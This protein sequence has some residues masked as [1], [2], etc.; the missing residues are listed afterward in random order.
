MPRE[1]AFTK[2]RRL[3]AAA[4]VTV[5]RADS[6]GV[7]AFCKGD[8]GTRL[9]T[10]ERGAWHCDCPAIGPCSHGLAVAAVVLVPPR[11]ATEAAAFVGMG[12]A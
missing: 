3:L 11:T 9:V 12:V 7:V 4:A 2:S 6:G 5:V 10:Y 1:N 8:S